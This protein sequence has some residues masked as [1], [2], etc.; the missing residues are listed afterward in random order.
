[1]ETELKEKMSK[2]EEE[3]R[4]LRLKEKH[5]MQKA[6]QARARWLEHAAY[7]YD[8]ITLGVRGGMYFNII[9]LSDA[10]PGITR[11]ACSSTFA[12]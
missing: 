3:C 5:L 11:N 1:M 7:T 6:N 9:W 4:H 8:T 2:L 10:L 12:M